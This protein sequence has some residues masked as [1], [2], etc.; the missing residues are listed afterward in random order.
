MQLFII[1]LRHIKKLAILASA[2]MCM[3][4]LKFHVS[5]IDQCCYEIQLVV[6]VSISYT[7]KPITVETDMQ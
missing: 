6:T 7:I 5:I 1:K 2:Y 3:Y 4:V